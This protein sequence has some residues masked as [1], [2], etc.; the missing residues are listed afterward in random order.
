VVS[1]YGDILLTFTVGR[2]GAGGEIEIRLVQ[3]TGTRSQCR[4]Y[5]EHHDML[6]FLVRSL[7]RR[8]IN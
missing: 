7:I 8:G 6:G 4:K 3:F 2:A 5:Q 1:L